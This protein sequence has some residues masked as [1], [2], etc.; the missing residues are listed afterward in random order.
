MCGTVILIA[1]CCFHFVCPKVPIGEEETA[2]AAAAASVL[3]KDGGL[4]EAELLIDG[5]WK[6][7]TAG[8]DAQV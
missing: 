8:L 1:S 2:V 7:L 6:R 3:G 5:Q 4:L